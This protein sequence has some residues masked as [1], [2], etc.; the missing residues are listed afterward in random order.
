MKKLIYIASFLSIAISGNS[1][2]LD[3]LLIKVERNNPRLVALQKWLE[4]EKVNARTGIYPDN[5]E[6]TYNYLWGSPDAIGNQQVFEIM[7]SFRFPGYYTSKQSV[8]QLQFEQKEVMVEKAKLEVLHTVRK[9]YFNLVWFLKK[10]V[11]LE[12]RKAESEKLLLVMQQG[13]ERGEVS[14]PV[15][16]KARIYEINIQSEWKKTL[17]EIEV[18]KK[19][20][21]QL[22]GGAAINN[23]LF[24]YPNYWLLPE[25]DS[26]LIPLP[27]RNPDL[28][29]AQYEIAE[30]EKF[31]KLE[32]RN[33]LPIF[34]TGFKSETILDQRLQGIH[35]GITIPIWENKNQV[36]QA[37][38][39]YEWS[40]ASYQQIESEIRTE[41]IS[42]YQTIQTTFN[43][44]LQ[45][46]DI[47]DSELVEESSLELL[48]AGQISFP[49]YLI[50]IQFILDSRFS[51]LETEKEFYFLMSQL[52]LKANY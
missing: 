37:K 18:Q 42:L 13:F 11:L 24:E 26:L 48:Q 5:P 21:E 14:R 7:Q 25:L 3:S 33:N 19:L 28:R 46:K 1:Q 41:L 38:L 15:Y 27:N 12:R 9:A 34:Q 47:L 36:K 20:L 29:L 52:L 8:Q 22:N 30:S 17:S 23:I 43:N 49:E 16:D 39:E 40:Q 35:A 50:E 32:K 10:E 45:M 4:A 31:I 44:Y 6:V 51:F 2:A